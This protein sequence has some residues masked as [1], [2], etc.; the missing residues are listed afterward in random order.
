ML[1]SLAA[2][3]WVMWIFVMLGSSRWSPTGSYHALDACKADAVE[4]VRTF[5]GSADVRVTGRGGDMVQL[6]AKDGTEGFL[7]YICLPS[8]VNPMR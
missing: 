1:I 4:I 7:R 6:R 3:A 8:N 2:E 5:K